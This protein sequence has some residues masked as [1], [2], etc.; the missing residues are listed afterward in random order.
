MLNQKRGWIRIVEAFVAIMLIMGVALVVISQGYFSSGDTSEKI[1]DA[2]KAVLRQIEL[3]DS[4]RESI[5]TATPDTGSGKPGYYIVP[6]GVN[7]TI[8]NYLQDYAYLECVTL[9]CDL[10]IVCSLDPFPEKAKGK[11]VYAQPVAITSTL[12]TFE[13]RQIKLFCWVK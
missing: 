7:A 12:N 5:L 4:L 11:D 6:T 1:Y 9:I 10:D 8:N 2:Q 13:L 3:D